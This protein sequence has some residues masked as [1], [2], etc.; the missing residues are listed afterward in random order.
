MIEFSREPRYVVFK[1]TDLQAVGLSQAELDLLKD[2]NAK[3]DRYRQDAGK[4]Y[5]ECVVV[6]QDWPE[7]EPTLRAIEQRVRAESNSG[8]A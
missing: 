7:Y 8:S 5:L 4:S 1:A 3:I 6:E 2:L